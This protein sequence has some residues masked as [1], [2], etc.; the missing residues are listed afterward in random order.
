M[1]NPQ[2]GIRLSVDGADKAQS[3][4]QRV[5]G[6]LDSIGQSAATIKQALGG[7]AGAFAGALSVREFVQASDAVTTLQ[8]NLKLATGSAQAAGAAYEQLFAI[9]Q[10]SRV[11]FTEIGNTFASVS[12][13]SESLGLSQRQVLALTETIGNAITVSGA[14]AQ[15]SQAA[16]IQLGQ[17]LASGVLRGEE[18]NSVMEQTPRLAKALADGLGV[19]VGALRQLGQEGKLTAEAVV[20]AL[21]SQQGKLAAEVQNSVVTVGQAFT[22][23]QNASI[24]AAGDF[25]KVTGATK[26]MASALTSAAGAVDTIGRAFKNNEAT[27]ST[28]I[29]VLG[30]AAVA[31]GVARVGTSLLGLASGVGVLT[32]AM[33]A[34]KVVVSGLNPATLA[35]L[36]IGAVVGG[37]TAYSASK[38]NDIDHMVAKLKELEAVQARGP[39]TIYGNESSPAQVAARI[40]EIE[41]LR[42]AIQAYNDEKVKSNYIPSGGNAERELAAYNRKQAESYDDLRL[43][44]SGFRG[45]FAKYQEDLTRIQAGMQSGAISEK[46]GISMLTEL[47]KRHGEVVSTVRKSTDQDLNARRQYTLALVKD[48]EDAARAELAYQAA[49]EARQ[50]DDAFDEQEKNRLATEAQIKSARTY[51]EQ[52]EFETSLIGLNTEQRAL[53]NAERELEA[54]GVMA[55][56]VAHAAY[57]EKIKAA[58]SLQ[59]N[60]TAVADSTRAATAEWQRAAQQIEQSLTDALMRGFESGKGFAEV[61][62]D[63][64]ANMFKTLVLRPIVSAVVNPVAGAL[65][66]ALGLAGTANAATSGVGALSSIGAVSAAFGGGTAAG[67]GALV[68][69]G[70]TEAVSAGFTTLLTGGSVGTAAAGLGTLAGALGPVAAVV[71]LLASL[72]NSGTYHTGGASAYSAATGASSINAMTLGTASVVN[73]AQTQA[74]TASMV[75]SIVGILDSTAMTFGKAAGYQAA[76]AFAD[77]SSKDGAWGALVIQKG[78]QTLLDWAATQDS[79][80][81]PKTFADGEAG[82]AQYASAVAVS[83]RDLLID[84]TPEWADATLRALGESPT[85]DQ[86]GGAVQAI[87]AAQ[88]ALVTMGD[89]AASFAGLSDAATTS[90]VNALGGAEAS[91]ASLGSYYSN[92]FS[93][94]ERLAVS[95]GQLA[96]SLAELGVAMPATREEFRALVD[97]ALSTGNTGLAA[98]LI[99]LS[100]AF[101]NVT[102]SASATAANLQRQWLQVTGNTAALRALELEGMTASNRA[103][104]QQIWAYQDQATAAEQATRAQQ[105]YAAAVAD[106]QSA[107]ASATQ[108]ISQWLDAQNASTGNPAQDLA[109]ARSTFQQQLALARAGDRDALGNITGYADRLLSAGE[110]R[111]GYIE[112]AQL[113]ASTLTDVGALRS[114]VTVQDLLRSIAGS[115]AATATNTNALTQAADAGGFVIGGTTGGGGTPDTR[116]SVMSLVQAFDF[117]EPNKLASFAAL[118]TV[119]KANGYTIG[120][121]AAATGYHYADLLDNFRAAGVPEFAVGTNYVPRDMLAMIHEGE[122]VVPK[123]YNPAASGGLD[124]SGFG[125]GMD[126]MAAEIA[127]LRAELGSLR[128]A[129]NATAVHSADAADSLRTIKNNGLEVWNDPASPLV[130]EAAA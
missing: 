95:T 79:R 47:A 114:A 105:T 127:A 82:A 92:F 32:G 97:G 56:T 110:Q 19:S 109:S 80:W 106:A 76:T 36:G 30:G 51:L 103:L 64:V 24:K 42:S 104:Q 107:L 48:M 62:R 91:V 2:I 83:I 78:G 81:A 17:G 46:D 111:L 40:A 61:L 98:G 130:T 58:I 50:F 100:G 68:G 54:K 102:A 63:T 41:R 120:S 121:L 26:V 87:N 122:A 69:G 25:D 43:R 8:N 1:S 22:Q 3:D 89:A 94:N 113:R 75:Q 59:T 117:S 6:G 112:G 124:F 20:Q 15:A 86:L 72:D 96:S 27:I 52:L 44:L 99:N 123:A 115:T 31:V 39:K 93:E 57:I 18:L 34:L 65:T 125:R 88:A 129:A 37:A 85:L 29:G 38:A 49:F 67:F 16:L 12:R 70:F 74:M 45:D 10:R 5:G 11:N 126:A 90:L 9:A 7:L 4:L 55:G 71:G 119:L 128:A 73:S 13:A 60:R 35:L 28:T 33:T 77:D 116:P 23:L 118:A 14:S 66:G 21:Q 108:N 101:A 84:Q 53:A